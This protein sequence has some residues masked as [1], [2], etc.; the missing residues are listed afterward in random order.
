MSPYSLVSSLLSSKKQKQPPPPPPPPPFVEGAPWNVSD[1]LE[2]PV[3]VFTQI[4]EGPTTDIFYAAGLGVQDSAPQHVREPSLAALPTTPAASLVSKWK[5]KLS[6]HAPAVSV[7]TNAIPP[8]HQQQQQKQQDPTPQS[9]PTLSHL[10]TAAAL[11]LPP[12]S[13][14]SKPP[15]PSTTS[16]TTSSSTTRKRKPK[17]PLPTSPPATAAPPLLPTILPSTTTP[18]KR[19]ETFRLVCLRCSKHLGSCIVHGWTLPEVSAVEKLES[20]VSC[21]SC[22]GSLHNAGVGGGGGEPRDEE[23]GGGEGSSRIYLGTETA[24]AENGGREEKESLKVCCG[25]CKRLQGHGYVSATPPT[26]QREY[27]N[28]RW[29]GVGLEIVCVGC[30]GKY[31]F[32]TECGGGGR[33]RTGKYRPL[34]LFPP[35]KKTCALSHT[36]IS[37]KGPAHSPPTLRTFKIHA[38]MDPT[39]VLAFLEGTRDVYSDC[40]FSL[41]AGPEVM[42]PHEPLASFEEVKG[43]V[44][45]RWRLVRGVLKRLMSGGGREDGG[46]GV[47]WVGGVPVD[48]Y[49]TVAS[50]GRSKRA[51]KELGGSVPSFEKEDGVGRA[52]GSSVGLNAVAAAGVVGPDEIVAGYLISIFHPPLGAVAVL[53]MVLRVPSVQQGTLEAELLDHALS[54]M[55]EPPTPTSSSPAGGGGGGP[56]AVWI[57]V[58]S[59]L[60][61]WKTQLQKWGF[62]PDTLNTLHVPLPMLQSGA[63]DAMCDLST[64]PTS[65]SGTEKTQDEILKD[66]VRD[67]AYIRY[68]FQGLA[69]EEG[70]E[71]R[72]VQR[73]FCPFMELLSSTSRPSRDKVF[74]IIGG[75]QF[76]SSAKGARGVLLFLERILVDVA[77]IIKPDENRSSLTCSGCLFEGLRTSTGAFIPLP[78]DGVDCRKLSPGQEP[79]N[80]C[81]LLDTLEEKYCDKDAFLKKGLLIVEEEGSI[82]MG[83]D[84]GGVEDLEEEEEDEDQLLDLFDD[85]QPTNIA[86]ENLVLFP[87][88]DTIMQLR[89][90]TIPTS[91]ASSS[92]TCKTLASAIGV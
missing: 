31:A 72:E 43:Y 57:L 12:P 15:T 13:P 76:K 45:G 42:E 67:T 75:A 30:V 62:N 85:K 36:R 34:A 84:G 61:K 52:T 70:V 5:R 10:L 49:L 11:T 17:P 86:T 47:C 25:L 83:V 79:F 37:T 74:V 92:A 4:L 73:M 9:R 58:E 22:F 60:S 38:D 40:F 54:R 35:L 32:C 69:E 20:R 27:W 33:F 18:R 48:V 26:A 50:V 63:Y 87:G 28:G 81:L 8:H 82:V 29:G 91:S 19:T 53:D 66:A 88:G 65:V 90:P 21:V 55:M 1:G 77:T 41:M 89:P 46:G 78:F 14:S 6:P 7:D 44:A 64:P 39:H 3:E 71:R 80:N 51:Q 59:F 24:E 16:S 56:K 23:E 2:R 68:L